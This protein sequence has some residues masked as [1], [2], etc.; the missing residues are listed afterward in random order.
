MIDEGVKAPEQPVTVFDGLTF[1][2]LSHRSPAP[3]RQGAYTLKVERATENPTCLKLYNSMT[4][5][6]VTRVPCLPAEEDTNPA[7]RI[8][9]RMS[10]PPR[11]R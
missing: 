10:P 5:E 6:T 9:N 8:R 1:D 2:E 3:V 4:S 11:R 7:V